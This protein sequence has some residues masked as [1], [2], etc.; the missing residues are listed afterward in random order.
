MGL[1]IGNKGTSKDRY[2]VKRVLLASG[3][4]GGLKSSQYYA[5]E[6]HKGDSKSFLPII[7][8]SLQISSLLVDMESHT[9]NSHLKWCGD[10]PPLKLFPSDHIQNNPTGYGSYFDVVDAL[11]I[12]NKKTLLY[13]FIDQVV[14]NL[15]VRQNSLWMELVPLFVTLPMGVSRGINC[16]CN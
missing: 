8:E 9:L 12:Q 7:F 5:S 2:V 10:E 3:W 4:R 14:E 16:E 13:E 11:C 6:E 1:T 15:E